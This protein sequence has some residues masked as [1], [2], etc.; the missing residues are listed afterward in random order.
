MDAYCQDNI[1][2]ATSVLQ[3][4]LLEMLDSD[5]LEVKLHALNLLFNVSIHVNMFEEIS[6][7]SPP[8]GKA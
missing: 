2:V 5:L 7:F 1:N 3:A 8:R 6:F 4:L